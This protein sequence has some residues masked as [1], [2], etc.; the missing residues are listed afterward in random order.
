MKILA[1][2][3]IHGSVKALKIIKKKSK[4]ADL[5]ICCGDFT[6]FVNGIQSILKLFNSFNKQVLLIACNHEDHLNLEKICRQ[7]DNIIYLHN[8]GIVINNIFFFGN[9]ANGFTYDDKAFENEI[10]HVIP[11]LKKYKDKKKVLLTH[12]SPFGTKADLVIDRHC[13][14]KSIRHFLIENK[15]DYNF[16]GHIHEAANT[17]TQIQKTVVVNSGAYGVVINIS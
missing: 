7:Y 11:I 8:K 16:C 6:I 14:N 1:F 4:F 3:D 9:S 10:K 17:I 15:I 13:G 5:I 2:S 12:A